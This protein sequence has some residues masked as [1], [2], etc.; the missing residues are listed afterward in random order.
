MMTEI[1]KTEKLEC[2]RDYCL[3]RSGSSPA[4]AAFSFHYP[5][6]EEKIVNK[7]A[8]KGAPHRLIKLNFVRGVHLDLDIS[9]RESTKLLDGTCK[10]A[11]N[12]NSHDNPSQPP[13]YAR[14]KNKIPSLSSSSSLFSL[15]ARVFF[16]LLHRNWSD[17]PEWRRG[18]KWIQWA[19]RRK[20][21]QE[22]VAAPFSP[23]LCGWT[24]LARLLLLNCCHRLEKYSLCIILSHH[25]AL[26]ADIKIFRRHYGCCKN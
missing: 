13:S 12:L 15:V 3:P 5:N 9:R 7:A 6:N 11:E 25:G 17:K 26:R 10:S 2:G 8:T 24:S 20:I 23:E 21:Q 22:S 19:K 1:C 16:A 4:S 14:T 18:K